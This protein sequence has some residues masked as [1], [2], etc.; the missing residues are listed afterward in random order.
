MRYNRSSIRDARGEAGIDWMLGR[1]SKAWGAD[2]LAERPAQTANEKDESPTMTTMS[3]CTC[4]KA[5]SS[6][7]IEE[8]GKQR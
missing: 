8:E 1:R 6:D 4:V 7:D 2:K 5:R 3:E